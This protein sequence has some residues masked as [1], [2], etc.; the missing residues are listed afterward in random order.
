M[1]ASFKRSVL[2]GL[3][4]PLNGCA[5]VVQT[6]TPTGEVKGSLTQHTEQSAKGVIDTAQ[7]VL[8][9]SATGGAPFVGLLR[10]PPRPL[11]GPVPLVE[12]INGSCGLTPTRSHRLIA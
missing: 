5:S 4:M 3:V 12:F 11:R 7:L 9:A 2:V 1:N 10:D 8:P 6:P